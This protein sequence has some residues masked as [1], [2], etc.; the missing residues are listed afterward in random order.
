ML[1]LRTADPGRFP[2][3]HLCKGVFLTSYFAPYIDASGLHMPTYEDRLSDLAE[4]Y[5]SIFGLD[6]ELSESVPDYQLLSV[7]ARALDDASQLALSVY[8]S[9]NPLYAQGHALDLL[10]PLY[11]LRRLPGETD[12]K[13]RARILSALSSNGNTM[14]EN[15]LAEILKVSDV[16]QAQVHVND[17][18]ATDE[19]GIP[20][21]SICCVVEA[22]RKADI[23]KA[24]FRKKAPG[25]G[26]HGT[27]S[28]SVT[29]DN[30]VSHTVR[31][32]RPAE[33]AVNIYVDITTYDGYD[34]A[35]TN[36]I[37]QAIADCLNNFRIG[38]SLVVPQLYGISYAAAGAEAATFAITDIRAASPLIT[39][40]T[41]EL[42]PANWNSKLYT[43]NPERVVITVTP[44]S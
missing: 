42:V 22:G 4:S 44:A 27:T 2:G 26:T 9:R 34:S 21:H 18:N 12:A 24:I 16:R 5:R 40:T 6:A 17:T 35:T 7:I 10:L 8:N 19:K 3:R 15:L 41:R 25:I 32:S 37:G 11:G 14:A 29:D 31:F 38:Q 13:A 33:S 43:S 39:G 1:S 28:V 20:A 23:A 36:V 30:G